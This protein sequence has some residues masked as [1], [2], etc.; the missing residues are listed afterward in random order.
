V[1]L[2]LG[3]LFTTQFILETPSATLI[4]KLSPFAY[5]SKKC[6]LW[7]N[8]LKTMRE[9]VRVSIPV[10]I[11][12]LL[13]AYKLGFVLALPRKISKYPKLGLTEQS[14]VHRTLHCAMSG[15]LAWPRMALPL[16]YLSD[17]DSALFM[18]RC[19][20]NC[21]FKVSLLFGTAR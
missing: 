10:P 19:A 9:Y 13:C 16:H 7:Q 5:F 17:V 1:L 3:E 20:H 6:S 4:C 11:G 8:I 15:A 18:I 2:H 21:C 14:G 12:V